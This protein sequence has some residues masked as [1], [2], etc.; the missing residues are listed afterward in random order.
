MAREGKNMK[1]WET[2]FYSGIMMS[3]Y[4]NPSYHPGCLGCTDRQDCY[5]PENYERFKQK[6][7]ALS[8]F[9]G[10]M[11]DIPPEN[12]ARLAWILRAKH[13]EEAIHEILSSKACLDGKLSSIIKLVT[14]YEERNGVDKHG[15]VRLPA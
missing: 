8:R 9:L 7:L 12:A 6:A 1:Y 14:Q 10:D 15:P 2:D 3:C 5:G 11:D 13:L 4:L